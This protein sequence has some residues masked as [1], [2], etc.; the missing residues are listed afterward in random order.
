VAAASPILCTRSDTSASARN[1]PGA[2]KQPGDCAR[3]LPKA[4]RMTTMEYRFSEQRSDHSASG[5]QSSSAPADL[6]DL[7]LLIGKRRRAQFIDAFL[8][9]GHR[10]S[11]MPAA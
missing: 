5:K 3:N 2:P 10:R 1:H 7:P 4:V 11:R 6:G 9:A 8:K